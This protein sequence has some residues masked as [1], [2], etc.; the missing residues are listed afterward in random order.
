MCQHA[1]HV[2]SL[3][4]ILKAPLLPDNLSPMLLVLGV[5]LKQALLG[6]SLCLPQESLEG[7][8]EASMDAHACFTAVF[9]PHR[10]SELTSQCSHEWD[11]ITFTPQSPP[12][13]TLSLL[14]APSEPLSYPQSSCAPP[15]AH[16]SV[17]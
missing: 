4:W 17:S 15:L 7:M 6:S 13:S 12:G 11:N 5:G 14:V 1:Q 2:G 16:L 3:I 9:S 8:G 10:P